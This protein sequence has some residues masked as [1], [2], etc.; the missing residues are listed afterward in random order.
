MIWFRLKSLI[1]LP[2]A[3]YI[4]LMQNLI[5][6][7]FEF[8]ELI[9]F[10]IFILSFIVQL[11][12][13]LVIYARFVTNKIRRGSKV[14]P[15]VSV[16]IC[17]RNE[18]EN[19]K[20]YLPFVLEQDYSDFEVIVVNDCSTDDTD[21]VLGRF[22]MEYPRLRTT[23]IKPDK[24]FSHGKKL[25]VTI[26]IKAAVNDQLL[27]IDADCRPET[28]QWIRLMASHFRKKTAIVLGYG[29]YFQ[30]A[31]LLNQYIRYDTLFIALQY[32]SFALRKNPY[33]G[34]GRNLGYK[35]TL[36][37]SGKGFSNHVH[38]QSGDDDLFVNEHADKYN[39]DVEYS[40][41]SHT[42]S[43]PKQSF[44]KWIYQKKRHLSTSH[45]Y[46]TRHKFMLLPE[47]LSRLFFYTGFLI[48]L[49]V[50]GFMVLV[51]ASF[52]IRLIIQTIVIK[53]AMFR[54]NENNLLVNSLFFDL[55]A[56]FVNFGLYLSNRF[57]PKSHQWK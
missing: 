55:I 11:F 23:E 33:M 20:K 15:P 44:N 53:K 16:I 46:K 3:E 7:S 48:F 25:A 47:P 1:Y 31:G 30:E 14:N 57:R 12:F 38:L 9:I 17:A 45:L 37:Y 5:D 18:A 19:L 36:F 27:F 29:G 56:L 40:I 51:L 8:Q 52:G 6:L 26:G 21:D 32:F 4:V 39:T 49:F 13:Y 50:P 34:V 2:L 54:L 22:L 28:N 43:D 35:K 10:S 24:K 42:R 41:E